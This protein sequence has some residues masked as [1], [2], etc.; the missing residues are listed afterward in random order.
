MRVAARRRL[1]VRRVRG[2]HYVAAGQHPDLRVVD[3]VEHDEEGNATP[4]DVI[5]IDAIR[6]LTLWRR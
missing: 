2:L 3:P 1:G 4:T 6:V 5:R